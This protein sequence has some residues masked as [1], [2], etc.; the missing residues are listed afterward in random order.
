MPRSRLLASALAACVAGATLLAVPSVVESAAA[1]GEPCTV[2]YT[3]AER[4]IDPKEADPTSNHSWNPVTFTVTDARTV[5]DI[6]VTTNVLH[7]DAANL[8]MHVLSPQT[9]TTTLTPTIQA[10]NGQMASGLLDGTYTFDEE[11][12]ST[13]IA[14]VNPPPATYDPDTLEA[15]LEGHPG[16]GTW[17]LWVL[18]FSS[19]PGT[20]RSATL[21]LTYA[22]C[23]SDGDGVEE[24]ADNCPFQPNPDQA[25][26]DTDSA[27]DACD[28]DS[29]GDGLADAIDG[30]PAAASTNP[31][32]CPDASRKAA[33]TWLEKEQRLEVRISSPVKSC[34]SHAR[35][36]LWRVRPHRDTKQLAVDASG[37]GR[38]RFKVPRGPKYYVTVS[39]SYSSGAAECAS[40]RSKKVRAP[41]R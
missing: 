6:D 37:R 26:R 11:V 38:Y 7:P 5:V 39:P 23:D 40:A 30:C 4:S 34:A 2:G 24:K 10:L 36:K 32:G 13:K 41:R 33:L 35:I 18:N 25:D 14:G 15:S 1:A 16:T 29:D 3:V 8:A 22:T 31:T 12:A 27:G 9:S 17:S 28:P 19:Q 20:L 21:T